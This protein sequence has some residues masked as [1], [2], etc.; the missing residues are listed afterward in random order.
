M[1]GGTEKSPEN[2][3]N[4][5]ARFSAIQAATWGQRKA[6]LADLNELIGDAGFP[7]FDTLLPPPQPLQT[8]RALSQS[9]TM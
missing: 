2:I 8:Q 1:Q 4:D 9:S 6:A 7:T 3:L 5:M